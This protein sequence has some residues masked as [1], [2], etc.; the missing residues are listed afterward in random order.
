MRIGIVGAE[1]SHTVR[2]AHTLN[3][4]K[5][6]GRARVVMVWGE[7]AALATQAAKDGRI[8]KIVRKPEEM[9]G[10]IDG[11][12]IDHRHAKYHIPAA[13]PFVEA[14]IP[15]FVDKPFSWTVAEGWKFLQLA[16]KK[17]VPVTTFSIIPEQQAFKSDLLKQIRRAGRITTIHTA[18]PCDLK[19]KYGGVFF[20]GIHQVDAILRAFGS[21]IES[22]QVIKAGRGNPNAVAVMHYRNGGPIVTMECIVEGQFGF[23]FRAIGT[24]GSVDFTHKNDANPYLNGVK[25]FLKM[26]RTGKQPHSAAEMLEPVAVLA[27]MNK[28]ATSGKRVRVGK[29]PC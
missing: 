18:G 16:K 8:P 10:H 25:K 11:V 14:G 29:L 23:T 27:A 5:V 15:T 21:G 17:K 4:D 19:S 28:S 13:T 12:M 6:C 2:V 24:K 22:V 1:N 26:F 7:T 3:I 20:Y 9:I